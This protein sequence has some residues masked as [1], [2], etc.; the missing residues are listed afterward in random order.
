MTQLSPQLQQLIQQAR[1]VSFHHWKYP[2]GVVARFQQADDHSRYLTDDDLGEIITLAPQLAHSIE[3]G[4]SLRERAD[5]IVSSARADLLAQFPQITA[6]GGALYPPSRTEACWRDLWQF[7]RCVSYGIAGQEDFTS[8]AGLKA[9]EELYRQLNVP[10]D[11]MIFALERLK[12]RSLQL[13]ELQQ[14]KL[15]TAAFD[16]LIDGLKGFSY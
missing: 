11:A 5:Q 13:F 6:P 14:H 4:R 16:H 7:L 10:L 3:I 15:I 2:I 12:A 8:K 1:I 9:M